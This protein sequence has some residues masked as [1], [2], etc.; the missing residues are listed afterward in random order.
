MAEI[1][2]IDYNKLDEFYTISAL[3]NLFQMEKQ[4][5]RAKCEQYK[6]KPR[7]NEIGEYGFVKYDV[8]KLHNLLYCED[9]ERSGKAVAKVDDPWA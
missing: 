5:L 8:R 9:R 7:R 1:P 4:A 2:Y 3:C 6:V